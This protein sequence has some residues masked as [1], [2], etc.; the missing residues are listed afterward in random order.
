[1][2]I[3]IIP[4]TSTPA[5]VKRQGVCGPVLLARGSSAAPDAA[6]KAAVQAGT[7]WMSVGST[8]TADEVIALLHTGLHV[9][10]VDCTLTGG[11]EPLGE[12]TEL[13][14]D[15]PRNRIGVIL[16]TPS[17]APDG[18][19]SAAWDALETTLKHVADIVCVVVL[20]MSAGV[21]GSLGKAWSRKLAKA[22][23]GDATVLA[24]VGDSA[25]LSGNPATES[26]YTAPIVAS[27]HPY[28]VHVI[29]AAVPLPP[30]TPPSGQQA[31]AASSSPEVGSVLDVGHCLALCARSDRPDDLVTS[32]V[33]DEYERALGLVYSSRAS[34]VEAV[35]AGRGIYFSR[36]RGALWRKGD[37]S[38]MW[39]ELLGA[40]L[41]CD[42]DAVLFKVVQMGDPAAFCH[43]YTRSCWGESGGVPG[44]ERTLWTRKANAPEGSYTKRLFDDHALLRHKLLEEAQE[45][46]EALEEGDA[47]HVAAEAADLLYFTLVATAAAGVKLSDVEAHLD[48]RS[49]HIK[50]RRG[51]AKAHRIA[52]AAA[53]LGGD[54]K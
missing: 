2:L 24:V 17:A 4:A 6:F 46:H 25:S 43:R 44:L 31:A 38:G 8:A 32:V 29:A 26:E 16:S 19:S 41:D 1:M 14:A 54:K 48:R 33:T 3:P 30:A 40:V 18:D 50:R 9:A 45:L 11:A 5:D 15:V 23:G 28:G 49:L 34:L 51:D 53:E 21:A 12:L 22:A 20:Q 27:V 37:T 35:T 42:S 47:T 13:S 10:L 36:S 39:Q 52:A 7:T